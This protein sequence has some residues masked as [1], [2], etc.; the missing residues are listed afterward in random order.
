MLFKTTFWEFCGCLVVR[1]PAMKW[2]QS[3]IRELRSCKLHGAANIN[4]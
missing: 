1:I 2:I 3:L 4:K